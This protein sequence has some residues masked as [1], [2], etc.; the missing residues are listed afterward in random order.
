M[1]A[2]I[3]VIAQVAL[4]LFQ[5]L[6]FIRALLFWFPID[7]NGAFIRLTK[8][9][10]EPLLVPVRNLLHRAEALKKFPF[11]LSLIVLFIIIE[12]LLIFI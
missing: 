11:D 7:E 1:I 6:L 8:T 5:A 3:A 4:R 12:V 2:T 9:V 10:T